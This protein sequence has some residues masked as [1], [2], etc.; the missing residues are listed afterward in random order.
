MKLYNFNQF[1]TVYE[2]NESVTKE[3]KLLLEEFD[4]LLEEGI[5]AKI[6]AAV[7]YPLK[8]AKIKTNAKKLIQ[9]RVK[10]ATAELQYQKKIKAGKL[11]KEDKDKLKAAHDLKK[12]TLKDQ[13]AA[14][15]QIIDE[16]ATTAAL[17]RVASVGKT[18]ARIDANKILLK[19]A[20]DAENKSLKLKIQQDQKKMND[21]LEKIKNEET[22]DIKSDKKEEPAKE[23]KPKT[24][25]PEK[26]EDTKKDEPEKKEEPKSNIEKIEGDLTIAKKE[27]EVLST[28]LKEVTDKINVMEDDPNKSDTEFKQLRSKEVILAKDLATANDATKDIQQ[29]LNDEKEKTK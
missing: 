1:S 11:E 2:L 14:I 20:D 27:E 12:E 22:K 23:E 7:L 18:K 10:L 6:A 28:K 21:T 3:E 8:Y 4:N 17:K 26:K 16:L 24:D 29:A 9:A 5:G 13:E 25:K 19:V 15:T